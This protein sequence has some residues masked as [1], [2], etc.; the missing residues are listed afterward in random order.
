MSSG[1]GAPGPIVVNDEA[2]PAP[3]PKVEWP[4]A[5]ILVIRDLMH[6][7]AAAQMLEDANRV[8]EWAP[9][10]VFDVKRDKETDERACEILT[11]KRIPRAVGT[12]DAA[13]EAIIRH[14]GRVYAASNNHFAGVCSGDTGFDLLRYNVGGYYQEHIDGFPAHPVKDIAQRLVS[15]LLYLNADYDGGELHFPRQKLVFEPSPGS[16]VMFPSGLAYPHEARRITRGRKYVVV[17]WFK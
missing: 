11:V 12:W 14:A 9:A 10:R 16:I 8:T 15:F 1:V 4:E 5:N 7:I 3:E 17:S 6:P 2:V 13:C